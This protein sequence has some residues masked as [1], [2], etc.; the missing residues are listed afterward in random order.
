MNKADAEE[1]R[2][3]FV[4]SFNEDAALEFFT[5]EELKASQI[6]LSCIEAWLVDEISDYSMEVSHDLYD[7][8]NKC[9]VR[10]FWFSKGMEDTYICMTDQ[11]FIKAISPDFPMDLLVQVA[12]A[13]G[14]MRQAIDDGE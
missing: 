6:S 11:S 8:E 1:V 3:Q 13:I 4:D 10:C 2:A 5:A 14:N 12:T 9:L 7:E